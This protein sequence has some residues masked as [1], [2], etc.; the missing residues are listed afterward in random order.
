MLS[1]AALV[2]ACQPV[3]PISMKAA[4]PS[5]TLKTT[6]V[7]PIPPETITTPVSQ[8]PPIPF[9][10]AEPISS[11]TVDQNN[12]QNKS[13]LAISAVTTNSDTHTNST[14]APPDITPK[15]VSMPKTFDPK[16]F[17]GFATPILVRNLGRANMIRKEGPIEVWQYQFSSCVVDFFFYPIGEG[18]SQLISKNWNMRSAVMGDYL[19]RGN[20]H[21]EM[22]LY[23]QKIFSNSLSKLSLH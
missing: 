6:D 8:A 16:K 22:N 9:V 17:I 15:A 1:C 12:N 20:C 4:S 7:A 3:T 11:R 10:P 14:Q 19:D 13:N 23:H 21:N 2:M 5:P 18:T